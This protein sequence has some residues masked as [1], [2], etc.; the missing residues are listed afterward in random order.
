MTTTCVYCGE[1][2]RERLSCCGENH[3]TEVPEEDSAEPQKALVGRLLTCDCDPHS[4]KCAL[5]RVRT[6]ATANY[7]RCC[8]TLPSAF[9]KSLA[10]LTLIKVG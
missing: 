8:I 4:D 3:W 5:G 9:D 6:L 2:K 7:N 10:A 1:P